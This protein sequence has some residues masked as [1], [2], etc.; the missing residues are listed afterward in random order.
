MQ[1]EPSVT[2]GVIHGVFCRQIEVGS[3]IQEISFFSDSGMPVGNLVYQDRHL[4]S[5]GEIGKI[6]GPVTVT[7]TNVDWAKAPEPLGPCGEGASA[8][9]TA[10][11]PA[12]GATF[13]F[14]PCLKRIMDA[15]HGPE[16]L[17]DVAFAGGAEMRD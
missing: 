11:D 2:V 14:Q 8:A 6:A 4:F 1:A 12:V 10:R 15:R 7:K 3:A 13:N 5:R 16:Y 17:R 9:A